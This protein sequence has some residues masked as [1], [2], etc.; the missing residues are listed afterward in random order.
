MLGYIMKLS[1][2]KVRKLLVVEE[3][4]RKAEV[5]KLAEN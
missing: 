1:H 5:E 2:G 3:G 4:I